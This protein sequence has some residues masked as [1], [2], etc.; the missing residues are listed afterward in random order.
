MLEMIIGIVV[1]IVVAEVIMGTV[2]CALVTNKRIIKWYTKRT[3]K[4]TRE[5]TD[6]LYE[7]EG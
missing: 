1:G 3:L 6:E 7:E 4:L 2:A 5:I